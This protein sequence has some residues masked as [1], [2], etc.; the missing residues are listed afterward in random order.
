MIQ[1]AHKRTLMK[2]NQKIIKFPNGN[3]KTETYMDGETSVTKHYHTGRDA[4]V[5]ELISVTDGVTKIKHINSQ[6]VALK[7]EH[8]VDEK[9]EGM[10][11]KY[12]ASKENSSVKSTKMYHQG[13]LHGDNITYNAHSDIIKHEVFVA[14]KSVLKYLRENDD[15]N[16]ITNFE[17]LDK[18]N[19]EN[20]PKEENDRLQAYLE[21]KQDTQ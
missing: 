3:T 1:F 12:F 8:F 17:I 7:L 6:G 19:I 21:H 5:R 2:E 16:E 15:N 13:K 14:G 18:E 9:R 10:E 20:L 11:T 4:Y